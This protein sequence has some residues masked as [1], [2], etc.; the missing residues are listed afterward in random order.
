MSFNGH[1][2]AYDLPS[3]ETA[4]DK[5]EE[6]TRQVGGFG[7]VLWLLVCVCVTVVLSLVIFLE[8]N[9]I[10]SGVY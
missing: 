10:F 3:D 7:F 6:E 2:S 4:Y 1:Y 9:L 8:M 5:D